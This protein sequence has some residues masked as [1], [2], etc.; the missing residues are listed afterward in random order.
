MKSDESPYKSL[1]NRLKQLRGARKASVLEVSGAVEIDELVLNK[2]ESGILRPSE[3]ILML[4]LN[5][6][7]IKDDDAATVWQLAGYDAPKTE[8]SEDTDDS[9]DHREF[10]KDA[11][12]SGQAAVMMMAFDPRVIYSDGVDLTANRQ[13]VVLSFTQSSP[14]DNSRMPVSRVGVSYEQASALF[15]VLHKTLEQAKQMRAPKNLPTDS[16]KGNSQKGKD[17]K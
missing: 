15:E 14:T 11:M 17:A 5:Y 8:S 16:A 3:D 4:L 9:E 7:G 12:Q 6:F 13:G 2:F 10:I 1:G